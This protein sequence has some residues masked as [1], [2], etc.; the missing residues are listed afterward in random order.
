MNEN[1]IME[2]PKAFKK[3]FCKRLI[4]KF[5]DNPAQHTAGVIGDNNKGQKVIAPKVKDDTEIQFDPSYLMTDWKDDV[6]TITKQVAVN[7]KKY[8]ERYSFTDDASQLPCGLYGISDLDLEDAFNM[9]R[10]DPGKGFFTYHCETGADS[11]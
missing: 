11:N 10:F 4:K 8:V 9:Q 3:G 6:T 5:E 1:L 7:M 2:I